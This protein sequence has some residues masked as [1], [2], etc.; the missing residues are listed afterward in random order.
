MKTRLILLIL[1]PFLL[2]CQHMPVGT[3]KTRQEQEEDIL[4]AVFRYQF[5]HCPYGFVGQQTTFY[6]SIANFRKGIP[7]FPIR[8]R[9]P[10]DAFMNRFQ[11][12][13]P[14]VKKHSVI[15][16]KD[17]NFINLSAGNIKWLNNAEVE[18]MGEYS[19]NPNEEA[20]FL[21]HLVRA[22]NRWIVTIE[23]M[24]GIS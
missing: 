13:N 16:Y 1:L 20:L 12:Q 19:G 11:S 9:D 18:V 21:Y 4:E 23:R 3:P 5:E 17:S 15:S 6:L 2:S 24:I 14:Q 8:K 22:G 10:N 7:P